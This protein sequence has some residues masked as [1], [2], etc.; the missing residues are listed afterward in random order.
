VPPGV[1][2]QT[3]PGSETGTPLAVRP[4]V[5]YAVS[6][7]GLP[8]GYEQVSAG[9]ETTPGVPQGLLVVLQPLD[10]ALCTF[11]NADTAAPFTVVK[12]SDPPTGSTVLPGDVITYTVTA[13]RIGEGLAPGVVVTD[14]LAQVL[15]R[16]SLVEGSIDASAGSATLTGTALTWDVGDLDGTETITYQVRVADG[17]YGVTLTNVVTAPGAEPCVEVPA[18]PAVE[19]VASRSTLA[20][21]AVLA[22]TGA[23][24]ADVALAAVDPTE[25]CRTTSHRTPAWTLAK[26]SDPPSGTSVAAGSTITYTLT[27]TNSTDAPVTGAVVTDDLSRVLA[28]GALVEPPAGATI[29]GSTL[30]WA[31]P[32]LPTAG[33]T[34]TLTYQVRLAPNARGVAVTNLATPGPGGGCTV[35][36]TTHEVPRVAGPPSTG[37]LAFTGSGVAGFVAGA[38]FLVLAGTVLLRVGRRAHG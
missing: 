11:T 1:V 19:Q 31:V 36:T 10:S 9:C 38:L 32:D 27:A 24:V 2:A 34:A 37:G 30:T 22:E 7:S 3:V 14:D 18:P 4:G 29:S 16:A 17:A 6:E 28:Y 5:A 21:P 12:S 13:T 25:A 15:N 33:A 8:S 23:E 35:C 20:S 26:T